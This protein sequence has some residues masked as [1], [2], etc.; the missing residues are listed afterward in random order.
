M[1]KSPLV[2]LSISF[3]ALVVSAVTDTSAS[4]FESSLSICSRQC[5]AA[6]RTST[7]RNAFSMPEEYRLRSGTTVTKYVGG[8]GPLRA[9]S[10]SSSTWQFWTCGLNAGL[11][12][13][14]T[15]GLVGRAGYLVGWCPPVGVSCYQSPPAKLFGPG[16][17]P[18]ARSSH[19]FARLEKSG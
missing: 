16:V 14:R 3:L 9:S 13:R 2:A 8:P 6:A 1:A 18:P 4:V 5:R 15:R 17:L 12:R 19:F 10:V 7:S 11:G